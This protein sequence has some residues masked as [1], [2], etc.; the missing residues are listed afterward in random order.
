LREQYKYEYAYNTNGN[1]TLAIRYD[2]INNDW[3]GYQKRKSVFD[4]SRNLILEMV[5]NWDTVTNDWV[6]RYKHEITYDNNGKITLEAEYS[7]W[8]TITNDWIGSYKGEV[9]YDNNGNQTSSVRYDWDLTKKDWKEREKTEFLLDTSYSSEDLFLPTG[10]TGFDNYRWFFSNFNN[11]LTEA[12]LYE[13]VGNYWEYTVT[14]TY[15][16]SLLNVNIVEPKAINRVVFPN[17]AQSQFTVTNTENT[18]IQ[19]FN[20]VG[21]EVFRTYSKEESTVVEVGSLPQGVYM[22]KVLQKDG[23]FSVRKVVVN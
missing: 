19:L 22:L 20:M 16:Y 17:P 4:N 21:Q 13:W 23:N 2:W 11:M 15:Y 18:D 7:G 14:D 10:S 5:H 6:G 3:R 9:T 1:Q 8:D 12:N